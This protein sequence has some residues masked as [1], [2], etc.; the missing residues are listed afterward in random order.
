[1][2]RQHHHD[3]HVNGNV[4]LPDTYGSDGLVRGPSW[5]KFASAK[6]SR[7]HRRLPGLKKL[8]FPAVA[9]ISFLIFVNIVVWVAAGVVL[10][11]HP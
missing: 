10:H 6:A 4:E 7:T 1:M 8:P 5:L 11:Y 9:I 2:P 3:E